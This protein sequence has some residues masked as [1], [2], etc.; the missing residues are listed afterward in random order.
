MCPLRPIST[1]TE[2]DIQ[3]AV[4]DAVRNGL[5]PEGMGLFL[6]LV[7]WAHDS[8]EAIR[9]LLGEMILWADEYAEGHLTESQ[10]LARLLS[11]LPAPERPNR[12]VAGDSPL[13]VSGRDFVMIQENLSADP[14]EGHAHLELSP[15]SGSGAPPLRELAEA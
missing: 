7:D 1:L 4:R 10:Y 15:Q 11:I 8:D 2:R 12:V 9:D 6:S 13:A 5:D 3:D 14:P